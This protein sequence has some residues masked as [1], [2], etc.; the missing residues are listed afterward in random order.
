MDPAYWF[1]VTQRD[2]PGPVAGLGIAAANSGSVKSRR[3]GQNCVGAN[4]VPKASP[5]GQKI[6]HTFPC[7]VLDKL[8]TTQRGQP[9]HMVY[10]ISRL[11]QI[12]AN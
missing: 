7:G 3:L 2:D 8:A 12:V 10:T 1:P 4:M 11:T 5:Y 9:Q 6:I